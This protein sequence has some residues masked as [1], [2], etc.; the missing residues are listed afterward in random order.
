M[1]GGTMK[2]EPLIGSRVAGHGSPIAAFLI[3]SSAIRNRSNS[4]KTL[5]RHHV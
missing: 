2:R 4:L 5:G 1:R 3:Y